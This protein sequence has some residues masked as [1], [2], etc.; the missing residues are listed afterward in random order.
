M[1]K[2]RVVFNKIDAFM[3]LCITAAGAP[4]AAERTQILPMTQHADNI[5]NEGKPYLCLHIMGGIENAAPLHVNIF[6]NLLCR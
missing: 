1:S 5:W 2:Y 6:R 4:P 3:A